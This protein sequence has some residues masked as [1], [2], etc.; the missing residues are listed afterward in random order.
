M[1]KWL[2]ILLVLGIGVVLLGLNKRA[3]KAEVRVSASAEPEM[4]SVSP[5][6]EATNSDG[7][8]KIEGE[9]QKSREGR[10]KYSFKV[11]D[12]P[13]KTSLPLYSTVAD[14]GS[15]MT[16]P[17]N[18][19]SPDNKQVYLMATSQGGD[20]YLLFRADGSKYSDGE[21]H[22]SLLEYWNKAE[23]DEVILEVS[24]WAGDD[25]LMVYTQKKDGAPG[26]AYWFVTSSRKF[27]RV[28]EF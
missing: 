24:G 4:N 22:I 25:L 3:P 10:M 28:R 27:S 12:V 2:Y 18:S 16:I 17:R 19:W 5:L 14:P 11:V 23:R 6:E 26:Q 21:K 13:R 7:S 9:G 15:V 1:K 20:D 8:L